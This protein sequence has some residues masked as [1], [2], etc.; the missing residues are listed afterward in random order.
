MRKSK[1]APTILLMAALIVP[2]V[3]HARGDDGGI[4]QGRIVVARVNQDGTALSFDGANWT[5]ADPSTLSGYEDQE[6]SVRVLEDDTNQVQV[7][8]VLTGMSTRQ[9]SESLGK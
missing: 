8:S 6:V 1:V 2:A 4:K 7:L 3:V 5:V 9:P